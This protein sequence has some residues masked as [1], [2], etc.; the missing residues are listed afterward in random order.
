MNE[1]KG[2]LSLTMIF[3]IGLVVMVSGAYLGYKYLVKLQ[4]KPIICTKEVK[5]CPDGSTVSRTGSNCEFANCPEAVAKVYSFKAIEVFDP[6]KQ[7]PEES[8]EIYKNNQL[9]KTLPIK[10]S[11]KKIS[12]FSVSPSQEYV[13][14][15]VA[16]YG[17]TCVY[18]ESPMVINLSDFS[19]VNLE[20]SEI[21]K[22][23]SSYIEVKD[24]KWLFNNEIQAYMQF[25]S[26]N[27]MTSETNA[28]INFKIAELTDKQIEEFSLKAKELNANY[29]F[30]LLE[31]GISYRKD[32]GTY[33]GR[34]VQFA[35]ECWGDVCPNN[36]KY[37]ITYKDISRNDCLGI[38][39]FIIEGYSG[40]GSY[41]YG[42]CSPIK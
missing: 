2:I 7:Y 32:I 15:R 38:G 35:F 36:G 10:E 33:K 11:Y 21:Q 40:W 37:F 26:K 42:G 12:L 5:V 13:A 20:S 29:D 14:F 24:I 28:K 3:I 31:G 19:K 1:Q 18:L 27:C 6:Y 39:G 41:T 8:I 4:A 16:R 22:Y 17:G 30:S 23:N 34:I 9:V 25:G